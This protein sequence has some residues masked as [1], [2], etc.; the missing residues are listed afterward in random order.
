MRT[1]DKRRGF[2]AWIG[3]QHTLSL[4]T[5]D[6]NVTLC[7]APLLLFKHDLQTGMSFTRLVLTPGFWI[8]DPVPCA[9][10]IYWSS[11]GWRYVCEQSILFLFFSALQFEWTIYAAEAFQTSDIRV[12]S[13]FCE[14]EGWCLVIYCLHKHSCTNRRVSCSVLRF[15]F[16]F[17]PRVWKTSRLLNEMP[18]LGGIIVEF[19]DRMMWKSFTFQSHQLVVSTERPGQRLQVSCLKVNNSNR[20]AAGNNLLLSHQP[21]VLIVR[22][23]Q[24]HVH[25][26][27]CHVV[28][29]I[30]SR[31]ARTNWV[32]LVWRSMFP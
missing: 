10:W 20:P 7:F 28:I 29:L 11:L 32:A 6:A 5:H 31:V 3:L 19:E 13:H 16:R 1:R 2:R 9:S 12:Q 18:G 14:L 22:L 17:S 25:L 4:S 27:P 15:I 30:M 23:S 26:S 8:N 24:L 21:V